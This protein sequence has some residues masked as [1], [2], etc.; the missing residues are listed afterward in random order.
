MC[1][2]NFTKVSLYMASHLHLKCSPVCVCPP[3]ELLAGNITHPSGLSGPHS[4]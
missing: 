2:K 4:L 3:Q 1:V